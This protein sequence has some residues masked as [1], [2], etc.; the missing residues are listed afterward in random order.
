MNKLYSGYPWRAG[1]SDQLPKYIAATFI[2]AVGTGMQYIGLTLLLYHSTGAASSIGWL[3]VVDS[4]PGLLFSPWIGVL[5]DRWS[6]KNICLVSDLGRA[7]ILC[8]LPVF[9]LNGQLPVWI[10]YGVEFVVATFDRFFRPASLGLIRSLVNTEKLLKA[11]SYQSIA[12]QLGMLVGTALGGFLVAVS[13]AIMVIELNILSFILSGALIL[14]ISVQRSQSN[15]NRQ[16]RHKVSTDWITGLKYMK[17]NKKIIE[18]CI[19]N[20]MIYITLYVCNTLLPVFTERELGVGSRGFGYIEAAWAAGAII[21][22]FILLPALRFI[23][24]SHFS[25]YGMFFIAASL[26]LFS[27]SDFLPQAMIGYCLTGLGIVCSRIHNDTLIQREVDPGFLGRVNSV[28]LLFT[29]YCSLFI[30][31]GV[32]YLGD[33]ISVRWIYFMVSL[34]IAGTTLIAILSFKA[35]HRESAHRPERRF[36]D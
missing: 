27:I 7:L 9:Y 16:R 14:W 28:I 36:T 25:R 17:S 35:V 10:I 20:G 34:L 26:L 13:S 23:N 29:S 1:S 2:T 24:Q 4:L 15:G 31:L 30:Y 22:V 33:V 19:Y 32:G 18:I 6:H 11:N 12:N 3:F 21:G 5:V 8:L